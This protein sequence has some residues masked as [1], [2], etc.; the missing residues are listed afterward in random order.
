MD[1]LIDHLVEQVTTYYWYTQKLRKCGFVW[2][3][4]QELIVVS[5]IV[6]VEQIPDKA[7]LLY[8]D[9]ENIALV[10]SINHK[11]NV[12]IVH[13]LDSKMAICNSPLGLQAAQ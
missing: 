6:R 12:W 3:V 9:G 13:L 4:R 8:L 5:I 7:V 10:A 1:R 11:S 2:N